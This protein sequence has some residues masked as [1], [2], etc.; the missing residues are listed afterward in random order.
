MYYDRTVS[1][2]LLEALGFGP[3]AFL[4][5]VARSQHLADLQLRGYPSTKRCWAS[6]YCGLTKVIDV[7]ESGGAI[8]LVGTTAHPKWDAQWAAFRPAAAWYTDVPALEDYVDSAI[9]GVAARFTNEGA[10]QAMLCTRAGSLYSVVDR[11]AVIGFSNTAER[12]NTYGRLREP[13]HAAFSGASEDKWLVPKPFGGELDLLAIDPEG[14]LLVVE[15]KPGSSTSGITWAPLQAIF[16]AEL[17]RAWSTECG[18]ASVDVLESM[19]KQRIALELTRD[20]SR[21]LHHPIEIVPVVAIGGSP[22]AKA[23]E[24]MWTVRS[25]LSTAGVGWENLE[26]WMVEEAVA[27]SYLRP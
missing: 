16:Y 13:L 27:R 24:R 8:R 7:V 14:R 1:D 15:I 26:V 11:E 20:P 22:S 19:L 5:Q 23:I 21:R 6:L 2:G 3:F 4:T 25:R 17:F 12:V 18:R 10:V 9:R